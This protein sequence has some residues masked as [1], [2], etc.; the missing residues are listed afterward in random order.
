MLYF[1]KRYFL[2]CHSLDFSFNSVVLGN[3]L[4]CIWVIDV[5]LYSCTRQEAD[6]IDRAFIKMFH[7]YLIPIKSQTFDGKSKKKKTFSIL[8]KKDDC[9][10]F[11]TMGNHCIRWQLPWERM[12][13]QKGSRFKNV[14]KW[15]HKI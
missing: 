11:I 14:I 8:S 4:T 9:L 1:V 13:V 2:P 10:S 12:H 5:Y 6:N 7:N 15:S 3:N